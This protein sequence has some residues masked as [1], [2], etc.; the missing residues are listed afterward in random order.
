MNQTTNNPAFGGR[1]RIDTLSAYENAI[2]AVISAARRAVR[3]F[4]RSPSVGYNSVKRYELLRAFL[5]ANSANQLYLVLHDAQPVTSR[6]PRLMMLLREFNDRVF[7]HET[8]SEAKHLY[9]PFAVAD[10][11]HFAHRFHYDSLRGELAFDHIADARIL[12]QRFEDIWQASIPAATA[13]TLGL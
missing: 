7:I 4:D 12:V 6:C 8:S 5:R 11:N 13:S 10:E 3:I 1:Q 9:D 2:D